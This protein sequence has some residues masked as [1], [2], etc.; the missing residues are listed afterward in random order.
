VIQRWSVLS[1]LAALAFLPTLAF[2]L[3][4]VV[5]RPDGTPVAGAEVRVL[6]RTGVARTDVDGRFSWSPDPPVP[7]EVLVV[8]PGGRLAKPFPVESL[9]VDGQLRV[10]LSASVEE[11]VLVTSGTTADLGTAPASATAILPARDFDV[12]QP[13]NLTQLLENVAGVSVVSEGQAAV[14]AIR[15]LARGRTLI[16]IDGARVTSERRVGPS[17]T[18][19]DPVQ[20]ESVEVSRGPA[21]V[22]YGSDAFG[23]VINARTRGAEPGS[24]FGGRAV[25]SLG[26]G[27]PEQRAAL[28]LRHGFATGGI[29][30]QGHWREAD[31]YDS[32]S[33]EVF[34]S[35][36]R[37][38]GFRARA[39]RH[40]RSAT[41]SV[42]WQSDFGRDIERP[43]NNSRTVRFFY[44]TEDSHRF[45]ASFDT[46]QVAGFSRLGATAFLGS[47]AQVT[48]QDRFATATTNRS[49]ERADVSA[50]DFHVRGYAQR[51]VG[52]ARLEFG[53]DVNGR[54]DLEALDI[55]LFYQRDGSLDRTTTNVSVEEAKRLDAGLYA[56][57]EGSVSRAVSLAGGLRVDRVTTENRAG[58]FGD[59]DTENTAASGFAG[60]T[61][62]PFR[63]F[64]IIGQVA[65][66][67]R[68]PVL[69]DRYFRGPTGR[70]FITGNPDLDPET[71]RQLDGSLRYAAG[72]W[73]A[74]LHGYTY[75]FEDLIER[76][77]TQTD[78]FFFRNRG[79]ARV[80][81]LELEVQSALGHGFTLTA[82]GHLVRS[83]A[84]DDDAYLD[85]APPDT[86]LL[87]LRKAFGQRGFVQA[88]GALYAEHDR[89][90]PTEQAR[91][92]YQ[93]VDVG[94]GFTFRQGL[95]LRLLVR[96]LL[97]EERLVSPDARAVP[98]PGRSG[99][100][101]ATVSF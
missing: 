17:A 72:R 62:G 3:E 89:P 9:P 15:G 5:V 33:G 2:G 79:E 12:R 84:L 70:G 48:D 43:R 35:G 90:G 13:A 20:L 83:R 68:D 37:D 73:Q 27:V 97:D 49:V 101:T 58:F 88:R 36:Y 82:A 32:P 6:G 41:F 50:K 96:N 23:G 38:Y 80:R 45:T 51:P 1:G 74:A 91:P 55:G 39:D 63:G 40:L 29:A 87:E 21:T 56:T 4:G 34:N 92:G 11:M 24:G 22:A 85:D 47:Y 76:Y 61:A 53:L 81:G 69:S 26:E 94:G 99:L 44:P 42:S 75:N 77:S 54:R 65:R 14:P 93:L 19:M 71:S 31:D 60:V 28:E 67:F 64:T 52:G 78:F 46:V 25:G 18:Y 8:L 95:E 16:L 66:G 30:A 59:Q 7:F 100:L 57:V 98:A 10:E 86:V